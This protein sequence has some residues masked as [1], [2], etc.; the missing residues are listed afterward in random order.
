MAAGGFKILTADHMGCAIQLYRN[1]CLVQYN[2]NG[3]LS[4]N[5]DWV[6]YA[7]ALVGV[8]L[9][10]FWIPDK[11]LIRPTNFIS[12]TDKSVDCSVRMSVSL[13]L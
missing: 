2:E 3:M 12:H 4:K 9:S 10:P 1:Q 6:L 7:Y 5:P 11:L 13:H 8:S